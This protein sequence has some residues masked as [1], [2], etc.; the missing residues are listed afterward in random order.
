MGRSSG[1][2]AASRHERSVEHVAFADIA[3]A[4]SWRSDGRDI[5]R[6]RTYTSNTFKVSQSSCLSSSPGPPSSVTKILVSS[7]QLG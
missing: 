6:G 4:Q 7:E 1:V 5:E 2:E 3:S